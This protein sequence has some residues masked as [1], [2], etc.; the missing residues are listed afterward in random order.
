MNALYKI[1]FK[2]YNFPDDMSLN[3]VKFN[4]QVYDEKT[5][6]WPASGALIK[7]TRGYEYEVLE[8]SD[9][10]RELL[11]SDFGGDGFHV[12]GE[13]FDEAVTQTKNIK[14]SVLNASFENVCL[15][16]LSDCRLFVNSKVKSSHY[17]IDAK[18]C[19]E[20]RS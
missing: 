7:L 5:Q 14:R 6:H 20:I 2:V 12:E 10:F 8:N 17:P 18:I 9:E 16:G 19:F 4:V 1:S 3:S 11:K 13:D 15:D